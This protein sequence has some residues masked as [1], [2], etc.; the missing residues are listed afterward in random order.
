MPNVLIEALA[1]SVPIVS[2]RV[3]GIPELI[4]DC[5][6]LV[7]ADSPDQ[8]ASELGTLLRSGRAR[9]R[10]SAAGFARASTDYRTDVNWARFRRLLVAT[11]AHA[12]R[13][14]S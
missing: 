6:V 2:T 4:D 13:V 7:D 3:S 9:T 5:G 12:R 8:L 11:T 10:L 1:R 14:R